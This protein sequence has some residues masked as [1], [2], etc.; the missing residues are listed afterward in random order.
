MLDLVTGA[1]LAQV[2][3]LHT[4]GD[5]AVL[6]FVGLAVDVLR[7]SGL[8][9]PLAVAPALRSGPFFARDFS[10]IAHWSPSGSPY[11]AAR[12][13]RV[14]SSLRMMQGQSATVA[15]PYPSGRRT[16]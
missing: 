15:G 4:D 5:R 1:V 10:P 13:S 12:S 3:D 11:P 8:A 7:L 2:S 14:R 9:P 6:R 16:T